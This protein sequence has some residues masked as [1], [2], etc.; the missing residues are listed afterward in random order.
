M[1]VRKAQTSDLS[2]VMEIIESGRTALHKQRLPQWQNGQGPDEMSMG[3]LIEEKSCFLA[4]IDQ[5]AVAVGCLIPGVDEVYTAI[6]NGTWVETGPYLSI[7]R[8]AVLS[9]N[10]GRGIGRRFLMSLVNEGVKMGYHDFRIDTHPD[11]QG[12]IRVIQSCGFV[13][14]GEVQFPIPHG[15]RVAFQLI[16]SQ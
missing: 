10:A 4:I 1:E 12:M 7:H 16:C 9:G 2:K 5:E 8:F 15:E 13:Y 14:R 3:Q 6:T 11:N